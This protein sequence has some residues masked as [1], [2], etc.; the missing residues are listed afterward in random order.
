MQQPKV[1]LNKAMRN[2]ISKG[3]KYRKLP[4]PFMDNSKFIGLS[5][6]FKFY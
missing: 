4:W 2:M 5:Y 1:L 3:Q 6:D